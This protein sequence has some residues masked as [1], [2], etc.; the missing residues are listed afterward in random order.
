MISFTHASLVLFIN[1]YDVGGSLACLN[2]SWKYGASVLPNWCLLHGDDFTFGRECCWS[3]CFLFLHKQNYLCLFS[4]IQ[5]LPEVCSFPWISLCTWHVH[6]VGRKP[7]SSRD[8]HF[9]ESAYWFPHHASLH[10]YRGIEEGVSTYIQC[11]SFLS[12]F[13]HFLFFSTFHL[14][15][16]NEGLP[17]ST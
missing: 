1:Q 6:L 5:F 11:T 15:P 4:I 8:F 3:V 14:F 9:V 2:K 16:L 13:L 12:Y 7:S 10:F 17:S